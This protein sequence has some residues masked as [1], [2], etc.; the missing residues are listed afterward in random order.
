MNINTGYVPIC[1]ATKCALRTLF[2]FIP[3]LVYCD[4]EIVELLYTISDL[5]I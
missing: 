1:G 4:D 5:I 3:T 2:I